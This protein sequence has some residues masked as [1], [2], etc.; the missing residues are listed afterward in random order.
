MRFEFASPARIVFGD[1]TLREVA[2]IAAPLGRRA[3]IACGCLPD[4]SQ[5]LVE[6]LADLGKPIRSWLTGVGVESSVLPIE[7]EPSLVAIREGL[8]R[9][10]EDG[11]DLV[12]AIGGGSAL[13]AGKAI[14]CLLSNGGD[15]LD[16]VEV[17]GKGKPIT[18]PSLPF[19]AIPTTAGTGSEVTCNAV[20]SSTEHM[21]KVSLRSHFIF[22]RVALIDPELT[23]GLP[24]ALTASTGMDALT[25]VIEPYVSNT[26]NPL[27]D[28]ICL[29]GIRRG[30]GALRY[31]YH[32]GADKFARE[33]MAI[34]SLLGGMALANAKL[35]AVHG[36]AA[37]LG[38]M[39][40]GP[41]GAICAR[42][43]P[44]VVSVNLKALSQ[45]AAGGPV[46]E[47]YA[48]VAR[49]LSGNP[50]STAADAVTWLEGLSR[51]LSIPPLREY[52]LK[53]K[54]FPTIVTHAAKASSMKGNPIQLTPGELIE[55]LERAL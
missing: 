54:D 36:F 37:V 13:D 39:F 47:R 20:L 55:I 40:G 45:R 11:C 7:G 31:A 50:A 6:R 15:P 8:R 30:A 46:L 49:L 27:T 48:V 28:A 25:Q 2:G 24:P 14:S 43:L 35:G 3:L 1:G 41:H 4:L 5:T 19:I 12:I 22:P 21:M 34:V 26:A 51:D 44:V 33:E 53:T 9:A 17:I 32:N 29:E 52:G 10:E 38:G 42:L 23:Y 16:Y 18:K